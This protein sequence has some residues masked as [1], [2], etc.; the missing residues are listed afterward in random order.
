MRI[1]YPITR[2]ERHSHSTNDTSNSSPN[3]AS[4]VSRFA[5][6][7]VVDP[8]TTTPASDAKLTIGAKLLIGAGLGMSYR[9]I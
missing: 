2:C 4:D 9:K 1:N 7:L 8:M 5:R 6:K 3:I